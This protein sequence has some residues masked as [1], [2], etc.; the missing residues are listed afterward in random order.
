M[1]YELN[2][3]YLSG[4]PI[5]SRTHSIKKAMTVFGII[6]LVIGFYGFVGF[7]NILFLLIGVGG[8][9][10]LICFSKTKT[11]YV[12]DEQYDSNVKSQ[13]FN[14]KTQAVNALGI[15]ETE[16]Q[17]IEPIEFDGYAYK[18]VEKVRK[19]ND[20]RFRSNKYQSVIILFSANEAHVYKFTYDTTANKHTEETEVYF[21]K[22][23]VSVSTSSDTVEVLGKKIEFEYFKLTT[24]GGNAL[25]V[26]VFDTAGA[27]RSINAMRAL[28]REKKQQ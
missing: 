3:K 21:Y 2:K 11:T 25:S 13:L 6:L 17:E 8:L 9:V 23:I 12:S 18:D 22:D 20:G 26:S 14:L 1:D 7:F 4:L 24:A 19:G 28:L 5:D 27:Q 10:L 15:D 16:V